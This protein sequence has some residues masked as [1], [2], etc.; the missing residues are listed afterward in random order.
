MFLELINQ[1]H[2][3]FGDVAAHHIDAHG[4]QIDRIPFDG[5]FLSKAYEAY[6]QKYQPRCLLRVLNDVGTGLQGI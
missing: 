6:R 1:D 4:Q 5:T 2:Q 3:G